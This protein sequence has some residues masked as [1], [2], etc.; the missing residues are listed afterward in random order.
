MLNFSPAVNSLCFLE[1]S[2]SSDHLSTDQALDLKIFVNIWW[3]RH[4]WN[5]SRLS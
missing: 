5:T 4:V 1:M 3:S 2:H